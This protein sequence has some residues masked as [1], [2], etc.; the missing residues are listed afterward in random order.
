MTKPAMVFHAPYPMEANPTSASRLRPLRMRQAFHDLGYRVFDASGTVAQ[1]RGALKALRQYLRGGGEVDFLYSE[2]S[3][4]PNVLATSVKD[5]VAPLVDYLIMR[6]VA[7]TGARVGVFYRDIYWKFDLADSRGLYQ[8][9][10]PALHRLDMAGYRRNRVHLF[11]PSM[12]MAQLVDAPDLEC[13]AL[14]PAGDPHDIAPLPDGELTCVYVGGLGA[15]YNLDAFLEALEK[16]EGVRL[17]LCTREDQWAAFQALR[18]QLASGRVRAAHLNANQLAPLY[19][20]SHV[21]VLAVDPDPYRA[22]A[23]PV[24]LF[25]YLSYGRPIIVT[26]PTHAADL[27]AEIGAGWVVD[28]N[29]EAIAELLAHLRDHPEEVQAKAEVAARAAADHT[30]KARARTVARTLSHPDVTKDMNAR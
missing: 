1:R 17:Q 28:A 25:E 3:T 13:S 27:V 30:W 19:A 11:L 7:R 15:H 10:K 5:G 2:N 21:G 23:A 29:T 9:V 20:T 6:E 12:K 22:M 8:Q 18:P 16:T 4:Q 14:P 26:R 24:K